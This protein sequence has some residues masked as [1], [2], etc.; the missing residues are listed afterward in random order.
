ML[1]G[2]EGAE[3]F[4]AYLP[5]FELKP[6]HYLPICQVLPVGSD[7]QKLAAGGNYRYLPLSAAGS[8]RRGPERAAGAIF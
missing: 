8:E 6:A 4:W 1:I 3:N 2:A 7:W 5:G